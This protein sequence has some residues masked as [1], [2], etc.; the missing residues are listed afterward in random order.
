MSYK[1]TTIANYFIKKYASS[2]LTMTPMKLIKLT[3]ISY[4]WYL[5]LT[6]GQ[7]RLIDERP[8]AWDFG[9]V[10]PS[11]YSS[12]KQYGK[13]NVTKTIPSFADENIKSSDKEFLD[14][15]WEMY[16]RYDGIYLSALTHKQNTP[17]KNVYS[18]G[19]NNLITDEDI[20]R[21]YSTML[22]PSNS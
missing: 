16:G 6:N 21:H 2:D 7:R 12:L 22:K 11:L 5:A 13:L 8:Q 17:W 10:F 20:L 1:P 4:C 14:K 18:P 3:Y 19:M 9:S 15:M